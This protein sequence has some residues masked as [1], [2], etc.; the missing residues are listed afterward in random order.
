[1]NSIWAFDRTSPTVFSSVVTSMANKWINRFGD[2]T[3]NVCISV[4]N[5]YEFVNSRSR[6]VV[7]FE[8]C[9]WEGGRDWEIAETY[10][11]LHVPKPLPRV[12]EC[13][14]NVYG[15]AEIEAGTEQGK[16]STEY[17]DMS[18]RCT[19]SPLHGFLDLSMV[20]QSLSL[21]SCLSLFSLL[22]RLITCTESWV[23]SVQF[24]GVAKL[25]STKC[26]SFGIGNDAT[27]LAGRNYKA[28]EERAMDL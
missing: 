8:I 26:A 21:E 18:S 27:V 11:Y 6:L 23:A 28:D 20:M 19:C 3:P 7:N 2:W 22:P 5:N 12:Q 4:R 17:L 9:T 15:W 1:M 25:G 24:V 13:G 10:F 14:H 16:Y